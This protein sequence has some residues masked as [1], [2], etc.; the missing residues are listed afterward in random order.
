MKHETSLMK[1]KPTIIIE[2]K[3]IERFMD[4]IEKIL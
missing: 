4:I 1:V 2:G 3:M